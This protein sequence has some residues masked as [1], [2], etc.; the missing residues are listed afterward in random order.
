[1]SDWRTAAEERRG[2]GKT[3]AERDFDLGDD[4][5]DR[6]LPQTP[7]DVLVALGFDPADD[8]D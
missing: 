6:E 7:Q 8:D 2:R 5:G 1:M 3:Q 4:D